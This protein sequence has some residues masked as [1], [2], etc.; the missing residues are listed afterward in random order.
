MTD[1]DYG[2]T[3]EDLIAL[4]LEKLGWG[5]PSGEAGK[6][7]GGQGGGQKGPGKGSDQPA[8]KP[9]STG[10]PK[11]DKIQ[12]AMKA[13]GHKIFN[14]PKGYDLNIVGIRSSSMKAGQ[15]DDWITVFWIEKGSGKWAFHCYP[16]TTDPGTRYL[17]SPIKAVRK[18]GTAILKAGQYRGSHKIGKHR[19]KYT[20]LVQS[21]GPV[22]VYRDN[23]RDS[24]L[25]KGG[26]EETGYF[27]IN[28]HRAHYKEVLQEVGSHSAGCQVFQDPR[29]FAEFMGFCKTASKTWG[30]KFTYTLLED[31]SGF[32]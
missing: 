15:F 14:S 32:S 8:D 18:K 10:Y 2:R 6:G 1:F 9:D 23:D 25:D 20:A 3:L 22:T 30:P 17:K 27:G 12:A 28:V 26:T 16:A 21:G 13:K 29:H 31:V 4:A 24:F 11:L 7:G 5:S 19:G